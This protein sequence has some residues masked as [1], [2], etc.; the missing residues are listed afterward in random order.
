MNHAPKKVLIKGKLLNVNRGES[1]KSLESWAKVFGKGWNRDK[2]HRYFKVLKKDN[3]IATVNEGVTLRLSVTNY[4][5]YQ[6]VGRYA[7]P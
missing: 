3:M 2:V 1:V 7:V 4:D 5:K 6:T